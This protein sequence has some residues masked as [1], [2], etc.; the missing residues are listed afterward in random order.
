MLLFDADWAPSPRRVRM[1]LAE[2][3][4]E[5]ERRT[6]DLRA[7]EHLEAS[8][9]A[10]NPRGTLPALVIKGEAEPLTE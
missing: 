10:V 7:G 1:F 5:L 2:K 3:G 4:L 8:Y 9:L 6:I